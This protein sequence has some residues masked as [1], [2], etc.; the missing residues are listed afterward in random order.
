M[1]KILAN[2]GIDASAKLALEE[3]GFF[4]SDI[5]ISQDLL[6]S[7][8]QQKEYNVLLVRSATQVNASIL[9]TCPSLKLVGRA[10]VGMDNIDQS[11]A[12]EHKINVFNT[13]ASSSTS[14]AELVMAH[15]FSLSRFLHHSNRQMPSEGLHAFETLKKSYAKGIELRGKTLGIIGFGRIGQE[16]AKYALGIGMN[17][18]AADRNK[19]HITLEF[20]IGGTL[21]QCPLV[22]HSEL[23]VY[24]QADFISFHVPKQKD[25][26]PLVT[27]V[28]MIK[29]KKGVI[30]INTS[31][32]GIIHEEDLL[33]GLKNG[34]I[35]GAALDVFENEPQPME[36]LL[37]HPKI[38]L[39]PHIG[40][41]TSEAQ[42][43][44][45]AEIVQNI[46][47]FFQK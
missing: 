26:K 47:S 13:P 1:I 18:I 43:R 10:G 21:I 3:K 32:G 2:D 31:R 37:H 38:S 35:A 36:E 28:Q 41:S 9:S 12:L 20:S 29:M 27:S 8:I 16:L 25:G 46:V 19:Q 44:I 17:V 42:E 24:A 30:L 39:S 5:K 15:M 14:V 33:Q 23:D 34:R 45:G 40:A 4:V 11:C 6:A 7:E 22:M